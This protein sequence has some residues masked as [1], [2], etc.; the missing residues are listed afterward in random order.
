MA[1]YHRLD[2]GLQFH[3]KRPKYERTIEIGLY[4]AYNRKNPF[5]IYL[6]TKYNTDGTMK[7]V[8]N[9]VSI[10]PLIP[11]ISWSIKF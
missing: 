9:Q 4:N 6:S 11:S 7:Q 1:A 2:I 3:K 8:L 5:Y 10:F